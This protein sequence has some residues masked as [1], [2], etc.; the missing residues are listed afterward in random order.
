MYFLIYLTHLPSAQKHVAVDDDVVKRAQTSWCDVLQWRQ[1]ACL[2]LRLGGL[3]LPTATL[4]ATPTAMTTTCTG[5]A[6]CYRPSGTSALSHHASSQSL[7]SQPHS[8]RGSCCVWVR[9]PLLHNTLINTNAATF[10]FRVT[11]PGNMWI[12]ESFYI[13]AILSRCAM[14]TIWI[15]TR[16]DPEQFLCIHFL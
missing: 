7:S 14:L 12:V 6:S 13:N 4:S 15:Q 16:L 10:I 1:R 8:L 11:K 5:P 9:T 3:W 2:L